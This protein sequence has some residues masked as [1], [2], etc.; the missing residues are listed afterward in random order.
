MVITVVDMIHERL[1]RL[2]NRPADERFRQ[3]KRQCILA[4]DKV[5]CISYTTQRDVQEILGIPPER[6]QVVPLASS[7]TFRVAKADGE[8]TMLS[9]TDP[10]V[11]HV[12]MRSYHKNLRLVLKAYSR[13]DKRGGIALVTVGA[14]WSSKEMD[15]L[16]SLGISDRVHLLTNID[17]ETLC[18]LYN[19]ASAF[20][21]P[22]L[23]EGFGMPLLEAMACGC[24]V[25]ASRIPSTLEVA[26][27]CPI[28][29]EPT[30]PDDLIAA[31]DVAIAE[32]RDC[33]RVR[34]GLQ[35][36]QDYSWDSTARQTLEVYRALS[37]AG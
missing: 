3:R 37:K 13:W 10:Y 31:F 26:Q 17:D 18:Q 28:Y 30:Q 8:L 14:P 21:Y 29:F 15:Y 11:L 22:S 36:V 9:T 5:I 1:S 27:E 34:L 12:G 2:F 32:G 35:L 25:I 20:V 23:Y 19:Q 7:S 4:A 16:E 6:T 24:P 33:N